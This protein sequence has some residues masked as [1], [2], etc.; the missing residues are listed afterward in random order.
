MTTTSAK[1]MVLA[2]ALVA[3]LLAFPALQAQ[4]SSRQTAT[5]TPPPPPPK[6]KTKPQEPIDPNE[7]AGVRGPG[8]P[9]TVRVM[10]KSKTVEGAH[11][12]VKNANGSLAGSCTTGASGDCKVEV[13]PD[14][15]VIHATMTGRE[16]SVTTHV[17]DSTG[18]IVIKLTK[19]KT[20]AAAPAS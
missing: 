17:T 7:T 10:L 5:Q 2:C 3:N 16:G 9:V 18:P 8:S 13:G 1:T 20:S 11:V 6:P 19:T 12:V 14:D 4:P 15:Y